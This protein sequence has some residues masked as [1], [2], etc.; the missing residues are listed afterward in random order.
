MT[1]RTLSIN[2]STEH[3]S[4]YVYTRLY[5]FLASVGVHQGTQAPGPRQRPVLQAQQ[6]HGPRVRQRVH[7]GL[8]DGQVPQ[9]TPHGR[10]NN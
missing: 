2:Y 7:Q 8:R 3:I 10:L 4:I 5:Y 1:L 9:G 6:D